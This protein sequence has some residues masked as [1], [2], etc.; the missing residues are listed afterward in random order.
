MAL[1]DPFLI[2]LGR[3][4]RGH[5]HDDLMLQQEFPPALD[6]FADSN[7]RVDLG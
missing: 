2:F 4:F 1:P 3:T 7:V 6:W 5:Q